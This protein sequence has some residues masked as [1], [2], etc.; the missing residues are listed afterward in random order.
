MKERVEEGSGGKDRRRKTGQCFELSERLSSKLAA[1]RQYS[2]SPSVRSD[3]EIENQG[4][5]QK[6]H[7]PFLIYETNVGFKD[8]T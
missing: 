4:S 2:L 6:S 5:F 8:I 7:L 3:E 1:V